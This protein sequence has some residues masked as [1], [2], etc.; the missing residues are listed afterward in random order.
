[1][2]VFRWL[3]LVLVVLAVML[4]VA[5]LVGTLEKKVF[6]IRSLQDV[7]VLFGYD[8]KA[9]VIADWPLLLVNPALW[10]IGAPS[11]LTLGFL[12]SAC[13]VIAPST[14]RVR[15]LPP[16]PPIPR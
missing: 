4:L 16:P 5:D 6:V 15:A 1:M 2:L 10:I 12:G 9:H 14:K 13:A 8:T 7:I 11:W 3:S